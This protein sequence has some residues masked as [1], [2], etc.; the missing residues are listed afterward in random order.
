MESLTQQKKTPFQLINKTEVIVRFSEVDSLGIV[1][2][3]HY[4]KFFEDGREAFGRQYGL[5]YMD[6]YKNQLVIPLININ[7]DFKKIVKYNDSVIIETAFIDSPAAKIIFDYKVY[8]LSDN[9]LVAT[10]NST[11]VFMNLQHELHIT[12]PAF[13]EEWKKFN[14][15]I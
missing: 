15:L 6:V 4:L 12:V 3:G 9:E 13:F 8:R 11:Q 1:W 2:H 14:L 10:G 7:V 5:G